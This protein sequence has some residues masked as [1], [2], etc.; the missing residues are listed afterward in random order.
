MSGFNVEYG[1]VGFAII[2]LAEYANILFLRL[3]TRILFLG[4][5]GMLKAGL[6]VLM[7]V[8]TLV[9]AFLFV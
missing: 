7:I 8:V 6:D 2:I 9:F 5:G 3:L 4:G 1:A